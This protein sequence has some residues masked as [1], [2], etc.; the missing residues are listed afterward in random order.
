M[1]CFS[2]FVLRD[3]LIYLCADFVS[4]YF[5][6]KNQTQREEKVKIVQRLRTLFASASQLSQ[7]FHMLF[8]APSV[9]LL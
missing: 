3:L 4:N 7:P 2:M 5:F 9:V 1:F 8:T 6:K